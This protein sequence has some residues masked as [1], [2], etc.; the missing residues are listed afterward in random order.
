M[1]KQN[2]IVKYIIGWLLH[3]AN[4][5]IPFLARSQF[6]KLKTR[7]LLK[8]ATKTGTDIQHIKKECYHCGGTGTF[9]CDWK[10]PE[11]C[12]RCMGSGVYDEFWS[13][14]DKYN[15]GKWYFHNPVE[16]M[17]VYEPLFEGEALPMIEGYIHHKTPKYRLGKECA[18]WLFLLFDRKSFRKELGRT[19]SPTNKRTP[20][21][22]ISNAIF[23]LRR[24]NWR[25]YLPKKKPE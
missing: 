17:Y 5:D 22:I 25:N 3:Y 19:G 8:Y 9:K 6:Y 18:L 13:R 7:L 12:W 16:I 15:L 24:F 2:L 20:L 1:A 21:V 10:L 4:R 14:L 11:P 23:V